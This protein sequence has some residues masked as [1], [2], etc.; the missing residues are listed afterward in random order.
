MVDSLKKKVEIFVILTKAKHCAL[1]FGSLFMHVIPSLFII[2]SSIVLEEEGL[3]VFCYLELLIMGLCYRW[4]DNC[5]IWRDNWNESSC[6]WRA[7]LVPNVIIANKDH[8]VLIEITKEMGVGVWGQFL[9]LANL[10][11]S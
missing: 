6:V 4:K 7:M 10:E 5:W 8:Q 11:G 1:C 9:S 3:G 2:Q